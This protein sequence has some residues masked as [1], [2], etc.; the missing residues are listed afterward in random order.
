M[1]FP[2]IKIP[3]IPDFK[4]PDFPDIPN[5]PNPVDF[6]EQYKIYIIAG[7]VVIVSIVAIPYIASIKTLV[8]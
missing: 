1:N 6:I 7:G 8:S 4:V 3:D 5:I 2:K